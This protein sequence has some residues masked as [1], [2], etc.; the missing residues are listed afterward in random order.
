MSSSTA[1]PRTYGVA[2]G[3]A[4]ARPPT[5]RGGPAVAVTGVLLIAAYVGALMR[6]AATLP[7]D[8]WGA[9]VVAPVLLVATIPLATRV[10]RAE[11]DPGMARLVLFALAAKLLASVARYA[12]AFDVYGG[13]ADAA[14]YMGA[15]TRLAPLYQLGLFGADLG[16]PLVGTGVIRFITGVVVAVIGPTTLGAF[17]VFSWLG[18]WGLYLFYRAFRIGVPQGDRRRFALLVFFLPSLLYWPS[19]IGKEAWMLL[20]LGLAA[21][22]SARLL[23][24][25]RGGFLILVP[26]L[27]GAALVRPHMAVL[28]AGSVGITFLLRRTGTPGSPAGP[29]SKL[30]GAGILA[31]VCVV[32]LVQT[33][34]FFDVQGQG[35]QSVDSVL[36]RAESQSS[37]GGSE[38]EAVR[39]RSPLQLPQAL[40]TVLYRPFPFEVGNLQMLFASIEG[41][42]LLILTLRSWDRLRTLPSRLLAT[43]YLTFC[44]IYTLL[45]ATVFSTFGNFGLLTRQRAQLFPF[46]L[47][48]LALT[49]SPRRPPRWRA[50]NYVPIRSPEVEVRT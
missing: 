31:V 46:V 24:R 30:V 6:A 5:D 41:L 33:Q 2:V 7:Y 19:S 18:F 45:F 4:S 8:L 1:P 29:L 36:N 43:P 13:I 21:Y 14:G 34:R 26:A 11:R 22:G 32:A 25:R 42:G 12:V 16:V 9:L 3:R 40:V 48:F 10:A 50:R 23:A 37:Q 35:L 47:V 28:V 27:T 49:A 17:L 44:A 38:F 15:A 39:V 20:T